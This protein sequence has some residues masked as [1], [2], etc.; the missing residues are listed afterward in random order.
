LFNN[1]NLKKE[2]AGVNK[3]ILLGHL[4]KDPEIR[5]FETNKVANFSM[6]TS[7]TRVNRKT[8]EKTTYTEWHN[9]AVWRSSRCSRK[10]P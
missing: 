1:L 4:G 2:M 3:V 10:V 5:S 9:I 6:A 7:E 8:Q